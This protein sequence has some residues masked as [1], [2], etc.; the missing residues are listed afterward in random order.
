MEITSLIVK[1][2]PEKRKEFLQTIF[3]L[4]DERKQEN[5]RKIFMID[6]D[7]E[8]QNVFHLSYEWETKQE[9]DSFR[10]SEIFRVFLGALKT[11]CVG[12]EWNKSSKCDFKQRR[13][14]KGFNVLMKHSLGW[15]TRIKTYKNL[16]IN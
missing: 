4:Q 13:C 14:G 15:E 9:S 2:R 8:N 11:L 5:G 7:S 10:N 12:S 1:V 6:Q 16:K 3:S